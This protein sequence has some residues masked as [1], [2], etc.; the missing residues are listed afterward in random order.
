[1]ERNQENKEPKKN[2]SS[3]DLGLKPCYETRTMT[4]ELLN[5]FQTEIE[6]ISNIV[7]TLTRQ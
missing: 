6:H 1:M 3:F 7:E 4:R 2:G 5:T